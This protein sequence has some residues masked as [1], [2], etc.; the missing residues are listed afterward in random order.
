[1]FD[2]DDGCSVR[3]FQ[4]H[5]LSH[6]HNANAGA[7]SDFQVVVSTKSLHICVNLW[8]QSCSY[9]QFVNPLYDNKEVSG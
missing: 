2:S 5:Q 4:S 3:G 6:T 7:T 8:I 1:M 9:K